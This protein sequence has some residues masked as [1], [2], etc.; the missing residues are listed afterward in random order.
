MSV[1]SGKDMIELPFECFDLEKEF[2]AQ[3][4]PLIDA[5]AEKCRELGLPFITTVAYGQD[6]DGTSSLCSSGHMSDPNRTPLTLLAMRA[7]VVP[8]GG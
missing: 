8:L 4:S 2:D 3:V 7:L 1:I 5:L 6:A